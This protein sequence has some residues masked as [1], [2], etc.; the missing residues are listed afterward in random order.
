[1]AAIHSC[2]APAVPVSTAMRDI[3][4]PTAMQGPPLALMTGRGAG[5][6]PADG[7][8]PGRRATIPPF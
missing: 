1:M 4:S 8:L 5:A 6:H 3:I 7:G 2:D